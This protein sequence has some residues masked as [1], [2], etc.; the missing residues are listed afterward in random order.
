MKMSVNF[1]RGEVGLAVSLCC[2]GASS[3]LRGVRVPR[4]ANF[5]GVAAGFNGMAGGKLRVAKGFCTVAKGG[6]G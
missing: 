2:G 4:D 1:F 3:L 6:L 5:S